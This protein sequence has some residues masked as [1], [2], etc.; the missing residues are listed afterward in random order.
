MSVQQQERP[1]SLGV[2]GAATCPNCH[3]PTLQAAVPIIRK[4]HC[5]LPKHPRPVQVLLRHV[6]RGLIE[7]I[8]GFI[9]AI[10]VPA[11]N[12]PTWFPITKSGKI[13]TGLNARST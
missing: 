3:K 13:C 7:K 4:L 2:S 12:L 8:G 5:G 11:S 10:F 9:A 1:R 6:S